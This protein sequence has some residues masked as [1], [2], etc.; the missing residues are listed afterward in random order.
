MK[1]LFYP[2]YDQLEI[3]DQTKPQPGSGEVLL[4][5]EACGICGSELEAFKKRSPRRVPPLVMGHEFCGVVEEVGPG[6]ATLA[7]GE[8]VVSHSLFGCGECVRCM[9]GDSH[10]CAHRQSSLH[11]RTWRLPSLRSLPRICQASCACWRRRCR[12]TRFLKTKAS[13]EF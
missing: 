13:T 11:Y 6:V 8:R 7:A 10:L 12:G 2:E 5:V 9:R 4:R 3:A 1:T